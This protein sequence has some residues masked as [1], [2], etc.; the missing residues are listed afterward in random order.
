M[1][2]IRLLRLLFAHDPAQVLA[3]GDCIGMIRAKPVLTDADCSLAQGLRL[4]IATL[5]C[6]EFGQV[7]ESFS[8]RGMLR[9]KRLLNESECPLPKGFGLFIV[10]LFI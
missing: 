8:G 5:G 6:M 1:V 10:S 2:T 9:S 4:N 3:I 7:V